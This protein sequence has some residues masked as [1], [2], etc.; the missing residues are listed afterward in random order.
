MVYHRLHP[1]LFLPP[2]FVGFGLF[3]LLFFLL[4]K[5]I[6]FLAKIGPSSVRLFVRLSV[7]P[8]V[9]R[10]VSCKCIS[11]KTVGRSNLKIRRCMDRMIQRVLGN[12]SCDIDPKVK[13]QIMF[14]LAIASPSKPLDVATSNYAGI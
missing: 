13:G 9:C 1:S 10:S 7:R 5:G 11:S 14:F 8:S 4:K 3:V 6:L 2:L 12:V